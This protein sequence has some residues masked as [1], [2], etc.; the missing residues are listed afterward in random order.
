M[1]QL[2]DDLDQQTAIHLGGP[3]V[4]VVS[5]PH[6]MRSCLHPHP[7]RR[8]PSHKSELH[9]SRRSG[10]SGPW[11]GDLSRVLYL[12]Q[13]HSSIWWGHPLVE[14]STGTSTILNLLLVGRTHMDHR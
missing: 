6:R 5:P 7:A 1:I 4:T 9:S 12:R 13:Q 8:R 10:R 14:L 2:A 11:W 3:H